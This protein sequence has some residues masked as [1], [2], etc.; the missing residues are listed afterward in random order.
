MAKVTKSQIMEVLKTV[1]DKFKL[2]AEAQSIVDYTVDAYEENP[3]NVTMDDLKDV[4]STVQNATGK[5]FAEIVNEETTEEAPKTEVKAKLPSKKVT[6]NSVKETKKPLVVVP[7]TTEDKPKEET[8]KEEEKTVSKVQKPHE[9]YLANFPETLVS[10]S[11]K[12]TLKIRKDL[13]TI[14]DVVKAYNNEE[15]IIIATYW[16]K[17]L[18]R[19]YAE[20]YDP[21]HI[22]PNRPKSFEHDL[23]LVEITYANDLVVTGNSLYSFVPQIFL[24]DDF[25]QDEDGMRYANGCEFQVYEVVSEEEK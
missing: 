15:D 18:L 23:D 3:R 6:E 24:P 22:N 14:Q 1:G 20:G 13:V 4:I 16:T 5:N 12:E 21:M 17:K 2:N 7:K 10:T 19:Q 9:D 25:E 8:P 11:L